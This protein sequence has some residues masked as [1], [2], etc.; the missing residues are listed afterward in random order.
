MGGRHSAAHADVVDP[1][2]AQGN[3]VP[4]V[5]RI[6]LGDFPQPLDE[7]C[8]DRRCVGVDTQWTVFGVKRH[9]E[10]TPLARIGPCPERHKAPISLDTS[11]F[12]NLGRQVLV[13]CAFLERRC[14]Q[15][16]RSESTHRPVRTALDLD[17]TRVFKGLDTL[18]SRRHQAS[19]VLVAP[20]V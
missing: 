2:F 10:P 12:R 19:Q 11:Q 9:G 1:V 16:R 13:D 20:W 5:G 8:R 15:A 6:R 17:Q 14:A 7:K 18:A 3:P 4:F